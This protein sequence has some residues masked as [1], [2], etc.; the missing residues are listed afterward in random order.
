MA[1]SFRNFNHLFVKFIIVLSVIC[2]IGVGCGD[3]NDDTTRISGK[4]ADGYLDNAKVCLD[5][6]T[7]GK[8][9]ADEPNTFSEDGDFSLA[10]TT[11]DKNKY[12]IVVE[13]IAGETIDLDDGEL[14]EKS[15]VLTAPKECTDFISPVTTLIKNE[16]DHNP[17]LTS[18]QASSIISGKLNLTTDSTKLLTDYIA[19]AGADPELEN[20]HEV[21]K[22]IAQLKVGIKE[23][24]SNDLGLTLSAKQ[25]NCLRKMAND[26]VIQNIATIAAKIGNGS[27]ASDVAI[28]NDIGDVVEATNKNG[29][30]LITELNRMDLKANSEVQTFADM[31]DVQLYHFF[32]DSDDILSVESWMLHSGILYSGAKLLDPCISDGIADFDFDDTDKNAV[33]VIGSDNS[34]V[35]NHLPGDT[36]DDDTFTIKDTKVVVMDLSLKTYTV[37]EIINIQAKDDINSDALRIGDVGPSKLDDTIQFTA[38]DKLIIGT[39]IDRNNGDYVGTSQNF[40]KSAMEKILAALK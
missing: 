19:G 7:N 9:D 5:I 39:G 28:A 15:Y 30:D 35:Y 27:S 4:V 10:I 24:I 31:I 23:K 16:I 3:D 22:V 38:G 34:V 29:D 21:G 6:N 1:S 25:E 14:L 17:A 11:T 36:S 32:H 37:K 33:Y 2:F 13:I 8:C 12:P 26:I 18:D 40:N 20:L